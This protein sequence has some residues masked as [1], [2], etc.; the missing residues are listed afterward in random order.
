MTRSTGSEVNVLDLGHVTTNGRVDT[1]TLHLLC[2]SSFDPASQP[3]VQQRRI[4]EGNINNVPN[5]LLPLPD[6][7]TCLVRPLLSNPQ[8]YTN[9]LPRLRLHGPCTPHA[10]LTTCPDFC[11]GQIFGPAPMWPLP[12]RLAGWRDCPRCGMGGEYDRRVVRMVVVKGA[13][14][15]VGVGPDRRDPGCDL[16]CGVM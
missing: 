16:G 7:R 11:R 6:L 13:G 8:I 2:T 1:R 5:N 9:P 10:N 12:W 4:I 15:R 3:D 14:V